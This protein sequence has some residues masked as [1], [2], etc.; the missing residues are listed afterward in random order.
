VSPPAPAIVLLGARSAS[1]AD[2]LKRALPD[3]RVHAPACAACP[4]DVRF[5]KVAEHLRQCFGEGRP[6]LGVCAAG[7]LIRALAPLLRD[8][9]DEPPVLAVAEDG[10]AIVP[11]L[12]GH[13]GANELARTLARALGAVAAITT[14]GD[15]RFGVA[16]D[17]P[18]PGWRLA[19]PAAAK[20][21]MAGLLEGGRVRLT[22]EAGETGWLRESG[23]PLAQNGE[24]EILVTHRSEPAG[25]RRLVYHPPVL[26]LGVGCERGTEP[27]ELVGLAEE[28]LAASGLAAAAVAGIF[29]LERKAAEPAVHALAHAFGRPARFLAPAALLAETPRLENPSETVFRETGV[30]GV[31]EGAALAAVGAE[32]RLLVGKRR[33]RRATVAVALAARPL[34]AERIGRPRGRLAVVGIG[35]GDAGARTA[36]MLQA[37]TEADDLVG[38]GLY[39][40]LVADLAP[41]TQRHA[42]PLG[43]E[44]ERCRHALDLAVQG[45]RVA[46]LSSGDAGIYAMAALVLELL[47]RSDDP[48]W[49]RVELVM[50][51]GIS[52]MQ[53]AA[54]RVGAPLGHDFCAVSLSDLLTPWEVIERRLRAAAAADFVTA[55]YNPASRRRR[56]GLARAKAILLEQRPAATPV[57]L[58]RNLGRAE[59]NVRVVALGELEVEEVDMLTLVLV[60]SSTTRRLSRLHGSDLVYT[61]RGYPVG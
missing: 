33:S 38:Y 45:R 50:Y 30:W 21:F 19:D 27:A 12:G 25:P 61:P 11:L 42:F 54:A 59:E 4:A 55:L 23:L 47:E 39:L 46:L 29:S 28:T 32:G 56:E 34:D 18:P 10:S 3:A 51:P 16:P 5:T 6:I 20:A 44:M 24:F 43:A 15:G 49:A 60:G 36:D 57:V 26:A 37:V 41:L 8:K 9:R 1:L 58:A 40:D 31:A 48:A 53:A 17:A 35:P 14:A 7:I 22:V 13:R 2:R 52:A